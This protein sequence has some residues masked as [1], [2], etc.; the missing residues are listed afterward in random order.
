MSARSQSLAGVATAAALALLLLALIAPAAQAQLVVGRVVDSATTM[1]IPGAVVQAVALDGS[2]RGRVLTDAQGAFALRL[3]D[4]NTVQLRVQRIGFRPRVIARAAAS[5]GSWEIALTRIPALLDPVRVVA[6]QCRRQGRTSPVGFI[7]Q[8]RAGLLASVVARETNPATM[9]RFIYERRFSPEEP[10]VVGQL[11]RVDSSAASPNSFSAVLDAEGFVRRGFLEDG[12]NGQTY[13]APDAET[14]VD[15]GFAAGYCFRVMPADRQRRNQVGLGFEAAQ[16]RRGRVDVVG[17]LWIDTLARELRD[18]E[19]RYVGLPD[20]IQARSPGGRIEFTSLPNGITLVT[21][22]QLNLVGIARDPLAL[23]RLGRRDREFSYFRYVSGGEL[24]Q[25]AW[26]DGTA[27]RGQL[28]VVEGLAAWSDERPAPGVTFALRGSPYR[29]TSDSAGRVVIRDIVPGTYDL[30]VLDEALL[31]LGL[32]IETGVSIASDRGTVEQRLPARTASDYV[33]AYCRRLGRDDPNHP[34]RLLARALW[35]DGSP[36]E[37]AI[38]TA[39]LMHGEARTEV[40]VDGRTGNDGMIAIC[41]GL[42][43]GAEVELKVSAPDG[44]RRLLRHPLNQT[45]LLPLV[46]MRP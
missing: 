18:I 7:E 5:G 26:P 19:F 39:S 38:W 37:G 11:V 4:T 27:W 3:A 33:S 16:R 15:D 6:A 20:G 43:L 31:T 45:T 1:P 2:V 30:L 42:E 32:G 17:M 13:F 28:G 34:T 23:R 14:L 24:A 46:F 9:V 10:Q 36:M 25:A 22:W 35:D 40:E 44:Q 21:R 41:R 12:S 29:G 8:A